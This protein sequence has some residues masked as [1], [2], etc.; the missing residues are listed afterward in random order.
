[1]LPVAVISAATAAVVRTK[2]AGTR[3]DE[4]VSA[5]RQVAT[6]REKVAGS[7]LRAAVR[8]VAEGARATGAQEG[9]RTT[10]K[11]M[12][13]DKKIGW[14]DVTARGSHIGNVKIDPQFRGLGL[15]RK[16]Y[17]EVARR[18][19]GTLRSGYSTS[20]AAKGVWEAM[21]RS[22]QQI[23]RLPAGAPMKLGPRIRSFGAAGVPG[24]FTTISPERL[25]APGYTLT[26]PQ[27]AVLSK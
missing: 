27:K 21:A 20:P 24:R 19:G 26:L 9:G 10:Y 4:V 7:R 1:M 16:L 12:L 5:L 17:G 8:V 11:M 18:T 15:G 3:T 22:G 13:G 25:R 14:M 23:E 2:I 6:T